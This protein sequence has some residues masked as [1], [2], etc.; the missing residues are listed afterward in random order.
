VS[1]SGPVVVIK[2]GRTDDHDRAV[3]LHKCRP[4]PVTCDRALIASPAA[5][6]AVVVTS[7]DDDAASES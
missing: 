4:R 5:A 2:S 1:G 3:S 7:A 6:A